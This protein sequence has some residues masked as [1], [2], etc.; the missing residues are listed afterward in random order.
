MNPAEL[1]AV[2]ILALVAI[3]TALF[4]ITGLVEY[5]RER[6]SREIPVGRPLIVNREGGP[7]RNLARPERL[8]ALVGG[9][10]SGPQTKVATGS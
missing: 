8:P 5:R 10:E 6:A 1:I 2:S 3:A 9:T 7:R 4:L